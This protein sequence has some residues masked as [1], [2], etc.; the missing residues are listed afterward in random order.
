MVRMRRGT[1]TLR[2]DLPP[3]EKKVKRKTLFCFCS[4]DPY[5]DLATYTTIMAKTKPSSSKRA[6]SPPLPDPQD[7]AALEAHFFASFGQ[8]ALPPTPHDRALE[9]Q[10]AE[11]RKGK[12]KQ[13]PQDEES[14]SSTPSQAPKRKAKRQPETIVFGQVGG[15]GRATDDEA[16]LDAKQQ[17]K[18]FMV[19]DDQRDRSK[20]TSIPN[21]STPY[22][23]EENQDGGLRSR[24][25]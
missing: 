19:S 6:A 5:F 9:A 18:E 13:E 24:C 11:I 22:A 14:V 3:A 16:A 7:L 2:V 21:H 4:F 12:R 25:L 1:R 17:W 20:T 23:L 10:K 8:E 15:R